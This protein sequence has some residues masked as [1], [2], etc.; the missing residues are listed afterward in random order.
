M[1]LYS[2]GVAEETMA[3][4]GFRLRKDDKNI[5]P[6]YFEPFVQENVEIYVQV[7]DEPIAIFRGDGDMDRPNHR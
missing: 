1:D 2:Y 5:I 7:P 3:Q 6:N 4:A